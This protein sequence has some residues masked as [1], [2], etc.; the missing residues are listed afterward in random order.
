M[1]G[2]GAVGPN[3]GPVHMGIEIKEKFYRSPGLVEGKVHCHC[4][5]DVNFTAIV[6]KFK[7][8]ERTHLHWTTT[9]ENKNDHTITRHHR[10]KGIRMLANR[11]TTLSKFGCLSAGHYEFP[12]QVHLPAGIDSSSSFVTDDTS[13]WVVYW[14]EAEIVGLPNVT[15]TQAYFTILGE[16]KG[17]SKK[18]QG[19]FV[20]PFLQ[21]V[22]FCRCGGRGF[23]ALGAKTDSVR[24]HPGRNF[25]ASICFQNQ[26]TTKIETIDI[27]IKQ[28]V[29]AH[30]DGRTHTAEQ[31]VGE[32]TMPDGKELGEA[33]KKLSRK[34]TQ[35]EKDSASSSILQHIHNSLV[36]N[37][38]LTYA[39]PVERTALPTYSTSLIKVSHT[40]EVVLRTRKFITNPKVVFPLIVDDPS[41]QKDTQPTLPQ[42]PPLEEGM[43]APTDPPPSLPEGRNPATFPLTV[44]T[45]EKWPDVADE[46]AT[47]P[48]SGQARAAAKWSFEGLLKALKNSISV[49]ST[50]KRYADDSRGREVILSLGTQQYGLA[51]AALAMQSDRLDVA[52]TVARILKSGGKDFTSEFIISA[53]EFEAS[54]HESQMKTGLVIVLA[55]LA[56]DLPKNQQELLRHLSAS[57]QQG[58][59]DVLTKRL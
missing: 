44:I 11:V 21:D 28:T 26:S 3:S 9:S 42:H 4:V 53:I 24:V 55:P 6:L 27:R 57:E 35:K 32:T 15:K 5:S 23:M 39:V 19:Y 17:E 56:S 1:K 29:H 33:A 46:P 45:V 48:D 58:V 59:Q 38:C 14:M 40:A 7:G 2:F 52:V 30:A 41:S 51:V 13:F 22:N 25:Q 47:V 49:N 20:E 10:S 34:F 8:A 12:F 18:P 37:E 54:E 31:I 43:Q 16:P 36:S 50:L